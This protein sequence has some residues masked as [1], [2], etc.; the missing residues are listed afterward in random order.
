[1]KNENLFYTEIRTAN[2]LPDRSA[3]VHFDDNYTEDGVTFPSRSQTNQQFLQECDINYIVKQ[4][5]ATGML[6]HVNPIQPQ[7]GDFGDSTDYQS[8]L[9]VT[10]KQIGRAH[11]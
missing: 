1:M 8:E 3:D 10:G 6:S 9:I 4:N 2:M 7:W 11:V 5:Q